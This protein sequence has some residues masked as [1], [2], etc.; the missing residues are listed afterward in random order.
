MRVLTAA[1]L[2]LFLVAS[3]LSPFASWEPARKGPYDELSKQGWSAFEG[4]RR[5]LG[6][7]RIRLA[8]QTLARLARENPNN[9]VVGSWLQEAELSMAM[10]AARQEFGA[11]VDEQSILEEVRRSYR[12]RADEQHTVASLILA[13]RVET[14]QFAALGLLNHALRID[15][16]CAWA[17]YGRAHVLAQQEDWK[18]AR[19]SLERTLE[20]DPGHLWARRLEAWMHARTGQSEEAVASLQ[21][22]LERVEN[23]SRVQPEWLHEARLDLALLYTLDGSP[24]RTRKLLEQLSPLDTGSDDSVR[25]LTLEAAALEALGEVEEA[26]AA[27]ARAHEADRTAYLPMVQQALLFERWLNDPRRA[28]LVW[29]KVLAQAESEG[30]MAAVVQRARATIH[31]ERLREANPE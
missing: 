18:G 2:S 23:D 12:E 13:A 4:A 19:R 25:R 31:L 21:V 17:H 5:D 16:G 27:A 9:L 3:C 14:D 8:R 20:L 24:E 30:D 10:D 1:W 11:S 26:L 28:M 15:E 7:G 6:L 29:E 22:W